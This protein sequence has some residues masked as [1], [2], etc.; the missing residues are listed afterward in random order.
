[1]PTTDPTTDPMD[2]DLLTFYDKR[3]D[4]TPQIEYGASL[5]RY[6]DG[7]L[8][9]QLEAM[10]TW[11]AQLEKDKNRAY[12]HREAIRL[13]QLRRENVAWIAE[14]VAYFTG[15]PEARA[16]LEAL[17]RSG[18]Y[19]KDWIAQEKRQTPAGR[20]WVRLGQTD[21]SEDF[22]LYT[23]DLRRMRLV[24]MAVPALKAK[25]PSDG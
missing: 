8:D 14:Q 1:M 9:S 25:E 21:M 23:K 22:G 4:L 11:M 3:V 15:S 7:Q 17:R 5:E 24:L 18:Y 19:C 20:A 2:D 10:E 6:D 12:L 13:E 16:D